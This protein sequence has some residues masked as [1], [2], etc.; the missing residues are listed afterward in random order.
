MSKA[1]GLIESISIGH[2]YE[3][4]DARV[5]KADVLLLACRPVCSGKHLSMVAGDV[6]AVNT[7]IK[8]GLEVGGTSVIDHF[9]LPNIHESVI[10][11]L[12]GATS[13]EQDGRSVCLGVLETF[14]VAS[15]IVAADAAAKAAD[16][17]L[18][19]VRAAIGIGGKSYAT[20]VGDVSAVRSA[21]D[22]GARTAEENGM[23]VSKIVIPLLSEDV[24]RHLV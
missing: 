24:L 1:V 23:L 8:A 5:K 16:V 18:I 10:P 11:A 7:A 2:G 6:G 21:V 17:T 20:M 15:L 19:E 3:I 14:S 9:V 4:A 13:F 22:A 12:T